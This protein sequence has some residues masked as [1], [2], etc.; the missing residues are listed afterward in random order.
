MKGGVQLSSDPFDLHRA[1]LLLH[2]SHVWFL[3]VICALV[4]LLTDL[5]TTHM[6]ETGSTLLLACFPPYKASAHSK[7]W[8]RHQLNCP[9]RKTERLSPCWMGKANWVMGQKLILRGWPHVVNPDCKYPT[10][11]CSVGEVK[12][13]CA[14]LKSNPL[15]HYA[16]Q[17]IV[18]RVVVVLLRVLIVCKISSN[19]DRIG[20]LC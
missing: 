12:T 6:G 18:F 13:T 9:H 5:Q 7:Q 20:Y 3:S 16:V 8:Q 17:Y 10:H 2:S 19:Y 15:W 11:R 1:H 14:I 4:A